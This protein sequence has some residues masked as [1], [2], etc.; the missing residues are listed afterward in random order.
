MAKR[1]HE[2][3]ELQIDGGG[4]L[5]CQDVIQALGSVDRSAIID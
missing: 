5:E 3:W 2:A 1:F 4:C